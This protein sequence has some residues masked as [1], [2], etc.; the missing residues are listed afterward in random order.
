MNHELLRSA[1]ERHDRA[2]LQLSLGKDSVS[3]LH[4]ALP[5]KD[6]ITVVWVDMGDTA[7]HL[8]DYFAELVVRWE[9]NYEIIKTDAHAHIAQY[10]IPTDILP[11]WSTAFGSG[12]SAEKSPQILQSS[13]DCCNANLWQ[14]L[15]RWVSDSGIKL[16]IRGSKGTDQHISVPNGT[17]IDGIEYINPAWEM[18]D[19]DVYG[20]L[21][22]HGVRLP[23]QYELGCNHS[24]DCLS[25]TGWMN[26][27]AEK[28]RVEF[29]R[30]HYP[31]QFAVLQ[32]RTFRIWDEIGRQTQALLPAL[33]VIRG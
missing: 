9:L 14:P 8:K 17:V 5:W 12:F 28:Q 26:T 1:F 33:D 7:Q 29:V 24:C 6:R 10:G 3:V 4:A 11:V 21:A 16:V 31:A 23:K 13:I 15:H 30:D 18:T 19:D 22:E 20:Y 25:C 32:N 2:I 27:E